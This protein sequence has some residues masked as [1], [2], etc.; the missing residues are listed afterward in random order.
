MHQY[1]DVFVL[2]QNLSQ[3]VRND[4]GVLVQHVSRIRLYADGWMPQRHDLVAG[5]SE[6]FSYGFVVIRN[7]PNCVGYNKLLSQI[8]VI[9]K[10]I[11]AMRR[12]QLLWLVL[13]LPSCFVT[14]VNPFN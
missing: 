13:A 10:R 1:Y 7:M 6:E 2:E 4:P 5:V 11:L 12:E 8:D 14:L 3:I 9:P